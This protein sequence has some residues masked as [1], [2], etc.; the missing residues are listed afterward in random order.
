MAIQLE[1]QKA[2]N[3][4]KQ[5]ERNRELVLK[6]IVSFLGIVCQNAVLLS[7]LTVRSIHIL[8]TLD[9]ASNYYAIQKLKLW[10]QTQDIP[11]KWEDLYVFYF[12][13]REIKC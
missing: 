11:M 12:L 10:L 2:E 6:V 13:N 5:L 8:Y 9:S 4:A 1:K 7:L 3:D